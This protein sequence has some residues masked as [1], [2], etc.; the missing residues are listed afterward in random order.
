MQLVGGLAEAHM[1]GRRFKRPQR[2]QWGQMIIHRMRKSKPLLRN[3]R[4]S[5][6]AVA[7]ISHSTEFDGR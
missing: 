3:S 7:A 4:L 2:A 5:R 6:H 1:P